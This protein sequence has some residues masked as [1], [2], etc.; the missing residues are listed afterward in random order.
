MMQFEFYHP[1]NLKKYIY[2]IDHSSV[3]G[4]WIVCFDN[5]HNTIEYNVTKQ[6]NCVEEGYV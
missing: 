3:N 5:I 6:V 4:Q 2:S 1:K